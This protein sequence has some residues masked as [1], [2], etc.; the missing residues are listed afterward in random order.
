MGHSGILENQYGFPFHFDLCFHDFPW[1][2]TKYSTGS[3]IGISRLAMAME[4]KK[5]KMEKRQIMGRQQV[6]Q[7]LDEWSQKPRLLKRGKTM[8]V[9]WPQKSTIT[10]G[11]PSRSFSA[12]S[13]PTKKRARETDHFNPRGER[14]PNTF[15]PAI[16]C[17]TETSTYHI[18]SWFR[19]P[20]ESKPSISLGHVGSGVIRHI[21]WKKTNKQL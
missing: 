16:R 11:W 19:D 12:P 20:N 7:F 14:I 17:R 6:P 3:D 8:Q 1:T 5:G 18:S 2:G 9:W 10:G 4:E 15:P 21:S 13:F